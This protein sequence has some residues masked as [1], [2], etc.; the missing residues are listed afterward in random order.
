[1]DIN[2]GVPRTPNDNLPEQTCREVSRGG[3]TKGK[4]LIMQESRAWMKARAG[5]DVAVSGHGVPVRE[6]PR[7]P[8]P[9]LLVAC[10]AWACP[11]KDETS[12][13]SSPNLPGAATQSRRADAGVEPMPGPEALSAPSVG[14][15][16]F[17]TNWCDRASADPLY[18]DDALQ[19]IAYAYAEAHDTACATR[20]LTSAMTDDQAIAWV[21]YLVTYTYGMAGCDLLNDLPGGIG[22]FGPGNTFAAGFGRPPLGRDDAALLIAQYLGAFAPQLG[23]SEAERGVVESYLWRAAE[24]EIDPSVSSTLSACAEGEPTGP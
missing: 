20:K 18:L 3:S 7:S 1:M 6:R 11:S 8:L 15:A 5:K 16:S 2:A 10:A 21:N 12:V 4:D 13:S 9:V 22:V 23:L 24:P 14:E 19:D 17:P